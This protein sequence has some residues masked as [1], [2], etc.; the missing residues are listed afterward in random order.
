M[1]HASNKCGL[2]LVATPL[3]VVGA[4]D[5]TD[6]ARAGAGLG[7]LGVCGWQQGQKL[8]SQAKF[9]RKQLQTES[10]FKIKST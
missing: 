10:C 3:P 9:T 2:Q 4:R 6:A 5:V 7:G 1:L 8:S